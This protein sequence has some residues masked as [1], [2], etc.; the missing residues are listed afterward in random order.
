MGDAAELEKR[1]EILMEKHTSENK[2]VNKVYGD[3]EELFKMKERF[4]EVMEKYDLGDGFAAPEV[5]RWL[6]TDNNFQ[7]TVK[8]VSKRWDMS[9]KEAEHFAR[10]I[11]KGLEM[12]VIPDPRGSQT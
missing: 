6:V 3:N 7:E 5:A 12:K 9:I 11:S 4:E 1:C 2:A 8:K 10:W